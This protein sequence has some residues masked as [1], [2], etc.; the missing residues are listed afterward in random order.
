MEDGVDK[1]CK[2]SFTTLT[3]LYNATKKAEQPQPFIALNDVCFY[4]A[5]GASGAGSAGV[6]STVVSDCGTVSATTTSVGSS[7]WNGE[8]NPTRDKTLVKYNAQ[9][10][11][12]SRITT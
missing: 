2:L 10:M 5:A 4:S 8:G 9:K 3:S 7:L 11:I 12:P 6:S 1:F